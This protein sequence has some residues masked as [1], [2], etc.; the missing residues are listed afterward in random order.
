MVIHK[1][2]DLSKAISCST[3]DFHLPFLFCL[4]HLEQGLQYLPPSSNIIVVVFLLHQYVHTKIGND[5]ICSF[6]S[7]KIG[8]CSTNCQITT[9]NNGNLYL[10][11]SDLMLPY[12][13]SEITCCIKYSES[14]LLTLM[15]SRGKVKLTS[16]HSS[17]FPIYL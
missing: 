16:E 7:K 8:N 10:L 11:T 5:N 14:S 3:H 13:F 9:R 17:R 12:G 1:N 6:T 4:S 2:I 15:L